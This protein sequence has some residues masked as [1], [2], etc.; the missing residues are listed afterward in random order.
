MKK[1]LVLGQ[2]L[3]GC[4]F[5]WQCK[6][7]GVDVTIAG[8]NTIQNSS[9]VAAGI[10][11][12]ILIKRQ[13]P[14]WMASSLF[15]YFP[16]FYKKTEEI[17]K[18]RFFFS[19]PLICFPESISEQNDWM[20]LLSEPHTS[21]WVEEFPDN[22]LPDSIFAPFG[23]FKIKAC[24]RLDIPTFLAVTKSFFEKEN[25]WINFEITNDINFKNTFLNEYE[26][27]IFCLGEKQSQFPP[28]DYLPYRPA[29]GEVLDIELE[30]PL[31]DLMYYGRV[32]LVQSEGNRYKVGSTYVWDKFDYE[33]SKEGEMELRN[34][35]ELFFKG[36]YKVIAN[37][38]GI[39]PASQDR[40]PLLG[41]HPVL[42]NSYIFNGL[43]SK[44][45]SLAPYFA[46]QLLNH[47]L[48]KSPLDKEVDVKRFE[49]EFVKQN[50]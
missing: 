11:N 2:G 45:V 1:I 23:A 37:K 14:T 25:K 33:A 28:F 50:N 36:T 10:F 6:L 43:G 39:R 27:I 44:G 22:L 40:R 13:K 42:K 9:S 32:L 26:S 16:E 5:A 38:A 20:T 48:N 18:T 17:S 24:G 30:N 31:P 47:I 35:L 41:E 29:K 8:S 12:P 3:A 7:K 4:V 21:E 49:K 15:H 46:D 34:N 19:K